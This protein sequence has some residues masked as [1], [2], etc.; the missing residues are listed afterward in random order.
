MRRSTGWVSGSSVTTTTAR[1][2]P[3]RARNQKISGHGPTCSSS[4]PTIGATAG[5]TPKIII[6]LLIRRCASSPS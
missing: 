4:P 5:A 6:T 2:S 1:A 3:S